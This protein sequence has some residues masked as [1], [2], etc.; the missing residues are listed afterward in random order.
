MKRCKGLQVSLKVEVQKNKLYIK[1]GNGSNSSSENDSQGRKT[2]SM[3]RSADKTVTVPAEE[4]KKEK[5]KPKSGESAPKQVGEDI[6]REFLESKD[7]E[8]WKFFVNKLEKK[9]SDALRSLLLSG[10]GSESEKEKSKKKT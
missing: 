4:T 3:T 7:K 6:M 1:W 10:S 8:K 5:E 9:D 2:R